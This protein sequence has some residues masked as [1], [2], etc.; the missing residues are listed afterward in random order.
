MSNNTRYRNNT[1]R[2]G[3]GGMGGHSARE[4][5]KPKIFVAK[6]LF[7]RKF[8]EENKKVLSLF[9]R[10]NKEMKESKV[11]LGDDDTEKVILPSYG[12]DDR[13]ETLLI[14][15]KK[16]NIMIED[17]DLLKDQHTFNAL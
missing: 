8:R 3:R 9:K 14:L 10:E 1:P 6:K 17:G 7:E 12:D 4:S 2:G 15:V 16:F 13:D 11:K 5:S